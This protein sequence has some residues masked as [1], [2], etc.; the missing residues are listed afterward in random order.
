[1]PGDNISLIPK[2]NNLGIDCYIRFKINIEVDNDIMNVSESIKNISSD[3]EYV[4]GYYYYKKILKSDE[5]INLFSNVE[6]PKNLSLKYQEK[7]MKLNVVVDAIQSKK[8]IP[9]Y[10]S[11]DPWNSITIDE[12]I[13]DTFT[14]DGKAS[15][16]HVEISYENDSSKYLEIPDNFFENIDSLVP[17]DS[18]ETY[19][20]INN[21]SK[22]DVEYILNIESD[23]YLDDIQ[24]ELLNKFNLKITNS[25]GNI[26]YDG[27]VE[28]DLSISLGKYTPNK[29]D[30][31]KFNLLLSNELNNDYSLINF[32]LKW[33]FKLKYEENNVEVDNPITGDFII[34]N[35]M[36]FVIS[37]IGLLVFVIFYKERRDNK[38]E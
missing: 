8:F 23:K 19:V 28:N 20:D 21:K 14:I 35:I 27:K 30:K 32:N 29:S 33:N 10:L 12:C 1:M 38:Y 5:T 18:I 26:I 36:I 4:N 22:K 2:I 37:A 3:F 9:N 34:F 25:N 13:D 17:G 6:I 15:S 7:T 11:D 31:L 24:K 16:Q